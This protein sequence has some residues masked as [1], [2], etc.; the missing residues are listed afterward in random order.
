MAKLIILQVAILMIWCFTSSSGIIKQQEELENFIKD[1]V[2]ATL[3]QWAQHNGG[4]Q[5]AALMLFASDDN[6]NGFV[7]K[8]YDPVAN[9]DSNVQPT[10]PKSMVNYVATL[11]AEVLIEEKY[12]R[13]GKSK[14]KV[15]A[16]L[17]SEQRI[18]EQYFEELLLGYLVN[19]NNN[20]PQ[21]MV[22]YS[23]AVPC[24]KQQ[25]SSKNSLGCTDHIVNVLKQYANSMQVIVA[26]TTGG[27]SMNKKVECNNQDTENILRQNG[28]E[29]IRIKGNFEDEAMIEE[30]LKLDRLMELIEWP[31]YQT[32][33]HRL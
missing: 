16:F 2:I 33:I 18:F 14:K 10:S 25:C 19:N 15:L 8:P 30:L 27:G 22:L 3:R 26:Y 20:P 1:R 31:V 5:F 23:W 24:L 28:I 17:H 13:G 12:L 21:A 11:P 4:E 7:F 29:V 6:W 9:S 32:F